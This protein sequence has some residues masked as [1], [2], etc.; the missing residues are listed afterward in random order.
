MFAE[1]FVDPNGA[2]VLQQ[3]LALHLPRELQLRPKFDLRV[4]VPLITIFPN[5]LRRLPPHRNTEVHMASLVAGINHLQL[6]QIKLDEHQA[7]LIFD[8]SRN[9]GK[10][11]EPLDTLNVSDNVNPG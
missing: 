2:M 9:F 1:A 7:G 10:F 8:M 5:Y 3:R 6:Q 4:V 11:I